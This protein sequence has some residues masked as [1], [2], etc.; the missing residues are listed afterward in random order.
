MPISNQL[1]RSEL[2]FNVKRGREESG[3]EES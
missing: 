2:L 1:G 3:S